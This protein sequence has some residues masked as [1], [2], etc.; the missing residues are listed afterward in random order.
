MYYLADFAFLP[1]SDKALEKRR[2][3]IIAPDAYIQGGGTPKNIVSR[4]KITDELRAGKTYP[5]VNKIRNKIAEGNVF[6]NKVKDL[7]NTLSDKKNLINDNLKTRKVGDYGLKHKFKKLIKNPLG[8]LP[9]KA[10][11]A[12]RLGSTA[13][14]VGLGLGALSLIKNYQK[15][16]NNN[17]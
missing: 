7:N 12:R 2:N 17:N 8:S 11:I 6:S 10:Q 15:N 14:G 9:N 5:Y 3:M 4:A 13:V 16:R 1:I